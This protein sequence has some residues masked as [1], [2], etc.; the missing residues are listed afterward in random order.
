MNRSEITSPHIN[1]EI[2]RNDPAYRKIQRASLAKHHIKEIIKYGK[3]GKFSVNI[4]QSSNDL[5]LVGD[6]PLLFRRTPILF[7][8][9][10]EIDF[11]IAVS[12]N[13]IYSSTNQSFNVK[14]QEN[15]VNYNAAIIDQ[16]SGYVAS[17]NEDY[18]KKSI[19]Y[20][21]ELKKHQLHYSLA[22]RAFK[23]S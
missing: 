6:N 21:K 13:R 8:E 18:L 22:E 19:E 9:F 1:P 10:N 16:S 5:F 20:Y 2:I 15:W 12:S 14:S 4:H 23:T 7:S 17:G 3:K 11:L